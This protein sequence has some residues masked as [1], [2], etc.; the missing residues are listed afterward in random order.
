MIKEHQKG[1]A[2]SVGTPTTSLLPEMSGITTPKKIFTIA[3][4]R[5]L[6]DETNIPCQSPIETASYSVLLA[7]RQNDAYKTTDRSIKPTKAQSVP[8]RSN[9]A[10]TNKLPPASTPSTIPFA[11]QVAGSNMQW[12]Q[13]QQSF[14]SDLRSPRSLISQKH[15]M[16]EQTAK[17]SGEPG[18]IATRVNMQLANNFE[19]R[20]NEK[21]RPNGQQ[22]K[23]L[24]SA[25]HQ[26]LQFEKEREEIELNRQNVRKMSGS[27]SDAMA[28]NRGQRRSSG[29]H[30]ECDLLMDELAGKSC[31]I[32]LIKSDTIAQSPAISVQST[33]KSNMLMMAMGLG[34]EG[35]TQPSPQGMKKISIDTIFSNIN[36]KNNT[37]IKPC[38]SSDHTPG[39]NLVPSSP[40]SYDITDNSSA[41]K[42]QSLHEVNISRKESDSFA[43][44]SLIEA[45]DD[46]EISMRLI[47]RMICGDDD[48]DKDDKSISY[49]ASNKSQVQPL[50]SFFDAP[51]PPPPG[52]NTAHAPK[53]ASPVAYMQQQSLSNARSPIGASH[54]EGG[55]SLSIESLFETARRHELANNNGVAMSHQR[56]R[57]HHNQETSKTTDVLL[58][59]GFG[60][61]TFQGIN[62]Q[63][64]PSDQN[65][66]FQGSPQ[67]HSTPQK[68]SSSYPLNANSQSKEQGSSPFAFHSSSSGG[69][70]SGGG[71][72]RSIGTP[73]GSSS[74][75]TSSRQQLFKMTRVSNPTKTLTVEKSPI[76]VFKDNQ[77]KEVPVESPQKISNML[78]PS[79][80]A[81]AVVGKDAGMQRISI[82][83]LFKSSSKKD[84]TPS[85]V[86]T[87]ALS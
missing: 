21:E 47:E 63:D 55:V 49:G 15:G 37:P 43:D 16:K 46:Y 51:P 28:D 3:E 71:N 50:Y 54:L 42:P 84:A 45:D 27:T 73:I 66:C 58:K 80:S 61:Q 35:K 10:A 6:R 11:H 44:G 26:R 32:D 2:C 19:N 5:S 23:S 24:S 31:A 48:Y 33:G 64:Y 86:T 18:I 77:G 70:S 7:N 12:R 62:G 1:S 8:I 79:P 52:I 74:A 17:L 53:H 65:A 83:D 14:A 29:Y 36:V 72:R 81:A 9:I 76:P 57:V 13:P 30:D 60:S 34:S 20:N 4:L 56:D 68:S 85:V 87:N 22:S 78:S 25:E 75:S 39:S 82:S 41:R 67:Y 38:S 69:G 59:L 40:F